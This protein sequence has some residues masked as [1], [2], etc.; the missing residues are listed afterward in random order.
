M[1]V[2]SMLIF[3]NV[4]LLVIIN[5]CYVRHNSIE[6]LFLKSQMYLLFTKMFTLEYMFVNNTLLIHQFQTITIFCFCF[7]S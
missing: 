2:F 7:L 3:E 5:L 1:C 6:K 4:N